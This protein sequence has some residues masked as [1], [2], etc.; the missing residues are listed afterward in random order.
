MPEYGSGKYKNDL[1]FLYNDND[2]EDTR[3]ET[4][5]DAIWGNIEADFLKAYKK[6]SGD[7]ERELAEGKVF[8]FKIADRYGTVVAYGK[9]KE[10]VTHKGREV[11]VVFYRDKE[12][13]TP[14]ENVDKNDPNHWSKFLVDG[15]WYYIEEI[16]SD[17]YEV[18]IQDTKGNETNQFK[19]DS[20]QDHR[21][22]FIIVNKELIDLE[23]EK[24]ISGIGDLAEDREFHFELRDTRD[25]G[26]VAFGKTTITKTEGK[27]ISKP[28][29]FY[30]DN[31]YT[32]EIT[33]W[34]KM[35]I[36][37]TEYVILEDGVTYEL[38]EVD[39]QGYEV[40]YH[41]KTPA[42]DESVEGNTYTADYEN[43]G[44]ISFTVDNKD[45]LEFEANK[46]VEGSGAL[47]PNKTYEF[48]LK[49]ITSAGKPVVAYGKVTV[50]QKGQDHAIEFFTSSD[51]DPA[52]KITDWAKILRED[53]TYQLIE[54]QTQH[55]KPIYSGGTGTDSNEFQVTYN[56]VTKKITLNV[57]NQ[58]TFD[59]GA[60]KKVTGDGVFDGETFKFELL[61]SAKQIVAYGRAEVD[62]KDTEVPIVFYTDSD[63][64]A[65]KITDWTS[66]LTNGETYQLK[67]VEDTGYAITYLNQD[68]TETNQFTAQFNTGQSLAVHVENRRGKVPL[69]ETGGE[70]YTQQLVVASLLI[71]LVAITA[72][73]IE[74]RRKAG[75]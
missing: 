19:Y 11:E 20:K 6:V 56:D 43:G 59:F 72:G 67:E 69:P 24:K 40:T 30:T 34:Q 36:N 65:T 51:Y 71:A 10:V 66:V 62:Q 52:N 13:T 74:Y 60:T 29:T 28:I 25:D 7:D 23:A 49:D 48:E 45:T 26:V 8:E 14:I 1:S 5:F 44:K 31:T 41:T 33:S 35:E 54:T 9:T 58:D 64:P 55:Y 21:W 3:T 37:G 73:I 47:T 18:H 46:K 4:D 42:D 63:N 61:N 57:E 27:N 53:K 68:G 15:R 16:N 32:Q 70:G 22:R 38:V 17:G 75:A 12:Y 50:A 2:S 39:S